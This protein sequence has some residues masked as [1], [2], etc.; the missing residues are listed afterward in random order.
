MGAT[1]PKKIRAETYKTLCKHVESRNEQ[2]KKHGRRLILLKSVYGSVRWY[3]HNIYEYLAIAKTRRNPHLFITMTCNPNHP[4]IL[5]ALPRGV[6]PADIP[7]IVLRI[8][9]QQV[10]Q[11][12][13]LVIDGKVPGIGTIESNYTSN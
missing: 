1:E 6:S 2:G 7:D 3:Q 9:R 8:L 5:K 4:L 12:T 13:K 10:L 11:L